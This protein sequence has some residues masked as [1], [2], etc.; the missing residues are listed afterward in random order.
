MKYKGTREFKQY[1][2]MNERG[3][4]G[5][6][7]VVRTSKGWMVLQA[8]TDTTQR[9][10]IAKKLDIILDWMVNEEILDETRFRLTSY[11]KDILRQ[12][13]W[14]WIGTAILGGIAMAVM[15]GIWLLYWFV[16]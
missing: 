15:I 16:G 6:I 13:V 2:E 14:E 11:Q 7:K 5:N 9:L 8:M 4:I 12:R 1:L 3:R 10:F